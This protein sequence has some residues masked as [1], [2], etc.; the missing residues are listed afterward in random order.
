MIH[1][2]IKAIYNDLEKRINKEDEWLFNA[3]SK[4]KMKVPIPQV[5]GWMERVLL[6]VSDDEKKKYEALYKTS[7]ILKRLCMNSIYT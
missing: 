6:C 7:H 3:S 4:I 1:D 5:I 2:C